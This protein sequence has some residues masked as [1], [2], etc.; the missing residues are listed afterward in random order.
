ILQTPWSLALDIEQVEPWIQVTSLQHATVNEA[1]VKVVANLQYQIEN[2]GLK[3]F[4]VY[5]PTNA[6]NVRFQGDQVADFLPLA[7]VVT[8]GM[9]QWEI[10]LHRR[11][12]G[13]YFLQV[14]YQTLVPEQASQ[15]VLRGVQAAD[16]NLQRGFVTIQSAGRLQ[17]HV[18]AT[19]EA[20][21]AAEWQSIPRALQQDLQTVAANFAYRLVEPGF[22][23]PLKIERHD[24][25]KLLPAR[26]NN[27]TFISVISDAGIMLTRVRL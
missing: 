17:L 4:H 10:K 11:V 7:G 8:N 19:P 6:E 14:T 24:A 12:I 26:V 2:T 1:Q 3:A 20:L 18:E 15:T 16:V 5:I 21:Q 9:Q 22:S 13:A 27:I 25:A 23:L